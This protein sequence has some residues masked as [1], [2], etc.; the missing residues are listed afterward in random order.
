[1]T[2]EFSTL[3]SVAPQG[4]ISGVVPGAIS[5]EATL[6]LD[7]LG[8]RYQTA[9]QATVQVSDCADFATALSFDVPG[10]WEEPGTKSFRME[11]LLPK[12]DY[13]A[14][15]TFVSVPDGAARASEAVPFR[16]PWGEAPRFAPGPTEYG[17]LPPLSFA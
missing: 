1:M 4:A 2:A 17:E 7:S 12:K 16:T 3:A 5:A 6:R 14:R 11:G 9:A 13:W 8:D 15:V 10:T